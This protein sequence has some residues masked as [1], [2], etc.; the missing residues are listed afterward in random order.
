MVKLFK[1]ALNKTSENTRRTPNLIELQTLFVD[2][3]R[4][5]NDRPLTS[6]SNQPNDL[7]SI[8]PSSFLGQ[9]LSPNTPLRGLHNK[10]D[11]RRNFFI[12]RYVGPSFLVKL[13]A[14]L[15]PLISG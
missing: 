3:V 5:V 13:D 15:P 4:I 11:Q 7:S 12:K 9:H 6:V 2:A 1:S 8:T 14:I 10:G